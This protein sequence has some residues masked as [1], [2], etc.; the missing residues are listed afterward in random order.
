[1]GIVLESAETTP[2]LPFFKAIIKRVMPTP[3]PINPH[4]IAIDVCFKSF[5]FVNKFIFGKKAKI[6]K[7]ASFLWKNQLC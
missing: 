2:G 3:M 1:M 7:K 4:K 6:G 5:I